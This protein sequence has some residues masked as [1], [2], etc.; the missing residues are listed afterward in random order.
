MI[1]GGWPGQPDGDIR[2]TDWLSASHKQMCFTAGK[3]TLTWRNHKKWF[4][5]LC[6]WK[7]RHIMRMYLTQLTKNEE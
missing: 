3:A 7:T 1:L 2:P 5:I 4:T 6:T